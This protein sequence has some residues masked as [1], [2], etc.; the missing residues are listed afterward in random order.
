MAFVVGADIDNP[1]GVESPGY[2]VGA[3]I[4]ENGQVFVFGSIAMVPTSESSDDFSAAFVIATYENATSLPQNLTQFGFVMEGDD[5]VK[6]IDSAGNSLGQPTQVIT[7]DSI[8][9]TPGEKINITPPTPD[10]QPG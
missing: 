6:A 4:P 3:E 10:I 8:T 7:V 9:I 2:T 5:T 1:D